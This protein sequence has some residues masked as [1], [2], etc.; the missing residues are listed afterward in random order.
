MWSYGS[1]S[2]LSPVEMEVYCAE[3]NYIK[4]RFEVPN[5]SIS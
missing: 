1:N 5:N 2:A 4:Y 3:Y